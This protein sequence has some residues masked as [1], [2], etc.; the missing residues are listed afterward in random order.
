MFW[1]WHKDRLLSYFV[2]KN[3]EF[4][5]FSWDRKKY[6]YQGWIAYLKYFW[7]ICRINW[8]KGWNNF[9]KVFVFCHIVLFITFYKTYLS[10]YLL[11]LCLAEILF[12]DTSVTF[13]SLWR[14][15]VLLPVIRWLPE[16][17][18]GSQEYRCVYLWDEASASVSW[19]IK[20]ITRSVSFGWNKII[21]FWLMAFE[22]AFPWPLAFFSFLYCGRQQFC[23]NSW[24]TRHYKI[25]IW[26]WLVYCTA[27]DIVKRELV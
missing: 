19:L 26:C 3:S 4:T 8:L 2:Q 24:Y 17:G 11:C 20:K 25:G 5:P 12:E 14:Y 18:D 22:I 15:T 7:I 13:I 23:E 9:S 6:W 21:F 10:N 16:D 1:L 27:F